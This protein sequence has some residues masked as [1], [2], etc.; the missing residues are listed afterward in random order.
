M[1]TT[2]TFPI[3]LQVRDSLGQE[4]VPQDFTIQIALHGFSATGSMGTARLEH[5]A[6]VLSSGK[7]LVV[8][9]ID[10]ASS[11]MFDPASGTFTTGNTMGT[12]RARHTATLLKSGKV[13]IAGGMQINNQAPQTL[14][15]AELFDP[16]TG[17]F[18]PTNGNMI[19]A[20]AYHTAT[21]LDDGRVLLTGGVGNSGVF[22]MTAELF[23]PTTETFSL[24]GKMEVAR[25]GHTATLL[26][27]GKV[28]V[29][30]G[31]NG[32]GD[33]TTAE[34][35]DPSTMS[36]APTAGSMETARGGHT[37]TLLKD[38]TV[39]LAGGSS[40]AS[41]ELFD[42]NT[43]TFMPTAGNMETLRENHT[44]TLLNDGTVLIAGGDVCCRTVDRKPV[45]IS[46]TSAEL[47]A[48][49]SK[50]FSPTGSL[51][52]SR[53]F[54][55]AS[56]LNDRTVLVTGGVSQSTKGEKIDSRVL[57]SAELYH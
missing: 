24:T 48:P 54:H 30:G 53:F 55:T 2:P 40:N 28:L 10:I 23:D 46:I 47:Y 52:N 43:S 57:S 3:T 12:S 36:F 56:L 16:T 8:G 6:T 37:A 33:F 31:G 9:G 38:G 22:V 21:L 44:A 51:Q 11:E 42:P 34:I 15:S 13:L 4:S 25:A 5:T 29:A 19:D 17:M 18:T 50:T 14:A 1:T 27:N 32:N 35:F 41:A 39:L 45:P 49:A 7:V 26:N 20:R